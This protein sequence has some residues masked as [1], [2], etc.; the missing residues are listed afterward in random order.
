MR[1]ALRYR[2]VDEPRPNFLSKLALPPLL[3]FL[4]ATFFQPWGF[5]LLAFNSIAL[6]GPHRNR[7]LVLSI[8][9][10]GVYFGSIELLDMI[11]DAGIV[12]FQTTLYLF[13]AAI[14][15]GLAC[16]AFAFISQS[17]TFELRR[18]FAETRA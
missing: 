17:H 12:T 8:I 10:I 5:L 18:Y 13:V 11:V 2:I 9:P 16:A 7:E 6:N 3:V 14:G 15:A 4:V 1:E